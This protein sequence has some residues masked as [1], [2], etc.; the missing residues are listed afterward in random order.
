LTLFG[1]YL[2]ACA[3]L[4]G[5]GMAKVVRPETTAKALAQLGR[6]VP[7]RKV[8]T[9]AVLVR[10][11]ALAEVGLGAVALVLPGILPAAL[12]ALSYASFAG[13]VLVVRKRGGVLA[14]CGCFSTPDTPPTVAHIVVDVLLAVSA[15]AVSVSAHHGLLGSVLVHQPLDGVP[16]LLVCALCVWLVVTLLV[17]LPRVAAARDPLGAR[18]VVHR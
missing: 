5:A 11:A 2:V 7:G 12:V 6:A 8:S 17:A 9:L 18:G 15:L 1:P 4:V 13:F 16:L 3:L 14:T 10:T